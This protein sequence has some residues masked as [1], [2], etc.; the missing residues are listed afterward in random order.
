MKASKVLYTEN[1]N[2]K[3]KHAAKQNKHYD[4]LKTYSC[5][6]LQYLKGFLMKK[7]KQLVPE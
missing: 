6:N 1:K 3:G 7:G 4:I 5:V 2:K